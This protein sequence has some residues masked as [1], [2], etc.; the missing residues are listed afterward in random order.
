MWMWARSLII[1]NCI[2]LILKGSSKDF[3]PLP[4]CEGKYT[5][6]CRYSLLSNAC[7]YKRI[8]LIASPLLGITGIRSEVVNRPG[9]QAELVQFLSWENPFFTPYVHIHSLSRP[10]WAALAWLEQTPCPCTLTPVQTPSVEELLVVPWLGPS[11]ADSRD[12]TPAE[13]CLYKGFYHNSC[14]SK[15]KFKKNPNHLNQHS[16]VVS[17]WSVKQALFKASR[18]RFSGSTQNG[19]FSARMS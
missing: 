6:C 9:E 16:S 19:E 14:V 1:F 4:I 17:C 8:Q 12:F 18:E 11:C 10:S 13:L 5:P 15:I 7:S 2:M 3:V